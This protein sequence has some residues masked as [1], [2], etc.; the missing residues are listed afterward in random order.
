MLSRTEAQN[1][2]TPGHARGE[3]SMLLHGTASFLLY[4]FR[5]GIGRSVGPPQHSGGFF[6]PDD[7]FGLGVEIQRT[8]HPVGDIRQVNQRAGN[9]PFLDG[10]IQVFH[11]ATADDLG[12]IGPGFPSP[13]AVG[14]GSCSGPSQVL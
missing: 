10:R 8:A 9:V 13:L 12:E 6:V 4:P 1:S 7:L 2:L 3:G 11:L 5:H 14:P